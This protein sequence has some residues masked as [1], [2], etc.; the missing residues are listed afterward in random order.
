[1]TTFYYCPSCENLRS[2]QEV[3]SVPTLASDIYYCLPKHLR[4]RHLTSQ[5]DAICAVCK[6]RIKRLTKEQE[7]TYNLLLTRY[8]MGTIAFYNTSK[9]VNDVI[10][11]GMIKIL[12][13]D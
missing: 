2:A 11:L 1:M 10:R 7:E 8:Q 5:L 4:K 3:H 6:R 13:S 12:R 9:E